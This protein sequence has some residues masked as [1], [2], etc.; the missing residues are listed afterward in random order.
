MYLLKNRR[1]RPDFDYRRERSAVHFNKDFNVQEPSLI[2]AA[3][4][5]LEQ[6]VLSG[7]VANEDGIPSLV[8]KCDGKSGSESSQTCV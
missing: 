7:K 8:Y 2:H 6:N 1:G 3:A 4:D 5:D